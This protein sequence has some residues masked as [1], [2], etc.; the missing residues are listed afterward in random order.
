VSV[1]KR[2]E[3]YW[4]KF[5]WH[6]E[7][8][9]HSTEQSN[10]KIARDMEAKHRSDLA[11]GLV[12]IRERKPVPTLARFISDRFRPWADATFATNSPRTWSN[13]YKPALAKISA[14]EPL[15]AMH[16]DAITSEDISGYSASLRTDGLKANSVNRILECLRRALRLACEWGVLPGQCPKV[17]MVTGGAHRDRVLTQAEE[18]KY[19]L[20]AAPLL[21]D[22]ATIL[23]DSGQRP[24]ELFRLEWQNVVWVNGRSGLIRVTHGKTPSARRE[25]PMLPR[26]RVILENR[27]LTAGKPEAG[28]VFPAPTA[29]GHIEP[30]SI[31]KQ[32][33]NALKL[34]GVQPFVLY[35]LRHS[36][37]T[38]LGAS[39]C[40][41]WSLS[42]IAGHSTIAMS[43]RY[44]HPQADVML[45]AMDRLTSN[46][47]HSFGHSPESGV[48]AL[49]ASGS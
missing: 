14:Y 6:G 7:S 29:S 10:G 33:G 35:S 39:G 24:E 31:K 30:S 26:V 36:F 22:V 5:S 23:L 11:Q 37:L 47:G 19:L 9:R 15:A 1:Y 38:R 48:L 49:P 28:F 44:V 16:L 4:Y 3:I 21:S 18:Q 34:S 8:I 2:G 40:D 46:D 17:P 45:S 20:V 27:W 25:I 41:A 32:H 12:G 42:R 43:T 13:W